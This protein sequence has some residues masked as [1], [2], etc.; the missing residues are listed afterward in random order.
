[1]GDIKRDKKGFYIF[2]KED[3]DDIKYCPHL[4]TSELMARYLSPFKKQKK[5]NENINEIDK[6]LDKLLDNL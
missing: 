1:M 6:F 4:W 3:R 5:V 2:I